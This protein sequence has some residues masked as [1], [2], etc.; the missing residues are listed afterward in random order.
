MDQG[1]LEPLL[2]RV[3]SPGRALNSPRSLWGRKKKKTSPA[4]LHCCHPGV[5]P[6]SDLRAT[7]PSPRPCFARERRLYCCR[8]TALPG[9]S[10]AR[11]LLASRPT[12]GRKQQQR[13]PGRHTYFTMMPFSGK[14]RESFEAV[15]ISIRFAPAPSL[16]T[17]TYAERSPTPQ[18]HVR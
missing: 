18:E 8:T 17:G 9:A 12:H 10:L 13:I 15:P 2:A 5:H 6:A 11:D 7:F 16:A 14:F 3:H 1:N 4:H